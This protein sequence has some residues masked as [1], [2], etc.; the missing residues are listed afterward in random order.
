M[1]PPSRSSVA[2]KYV[3][4]IIEPLVSWLLKSGI[5]YSEFVQALKAVFYC[6][7]KK[8]LECLKQ[9]QTVSSISLLSGLNRREVTAFQDKP[10]AMMHTPR[11]SQ[12][13]SAR[14]VT[15]WIN[16]KWPKQIAFNNETLSFETLAKEVSQDKHPR[17]ILLEL[18]RLN[19]VSEFDNTVILH[20][21]S[22]T[23]QSDISENQK[24]LSQSAYD[25]LSAGVSNIFISPNQFL[26]QH[27]QADELTE[28]SV[29]ELKDYS[30]QLWQEY[31]QKMLN[32]AFECAE[33]DAGK[34]DAHHRF[35]LGIYQYDE[36][37]D[38]DISKK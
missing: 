5:G 12:N 18:K 24:L 30:N 32:K 33:R 20:T 9:K 36:K 15:L 3:L 2:L 17:S 23:P 31:A 10:P 29:R 26:E 8:E 34:I 19:L 27:L 22:F 4:R 16:K 7:A 6:E 28:E 1:S 11:L 37:I 13:I 35:S 21:E 25:H 38:I 14:I